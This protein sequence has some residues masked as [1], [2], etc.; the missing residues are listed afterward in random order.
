MLAKI[1]LCAV[2]TLSMCQVAIAGTVTLTAA[3]E[4]CCVE[5][6]SGNFLN[7][8]EN[9]LVRSGP[10]APGPVYT[11]ADGMSVCYRRENRQGDQSS[12]IA[13]IYNCTSRG[14]SGN[15]LFFIQ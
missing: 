12:G 11:G 9:A 4:W 6:R 10:V 15:E 14:I 2:M 5:V 1:A 13:Q 3:G 7:A 8:E